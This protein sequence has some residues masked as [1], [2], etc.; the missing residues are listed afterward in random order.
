MIP[1]RA[2]GKGLGGL[3]PAL[4]LATG[5][6]DLGG[7][8]HAAD[9]SECDTY[10]FIRMSYDRY[11]L[12]L[13]NERGWL[14]H[15]EANPLI[16]RSH[17]IK[18][19]KKFVELLDA[20]YRLWQIAPEKDRPALL[21]RVRQIVSVTYQDDYHDMASV[22][23]TTF[24]QD[25]TSYLRAA[26]LMDRM[27]LDTARYRQEILKIQPRLD[28]HLTSRG[29]NQRRIF[30]WYYEHFGLK[31]PFPLADALKAG[32]IAHRQDP[33]R[34]SSLDIYLF[35]HEIFGPY[36]YGD[37]LDV[38]PFSQ[39]DKVYL[40]SALEVLI[41]RSLAARDPDLLA[42]LITCTRLLRLVS[43]PSYREGLAYL[44]DS[45]NA[46]GSWGNIARA[47]ARLGDFAAEGT[48]LH[49]T[50]VA[51]DALSL[52]FHEP[53]YGPLFVSCPKS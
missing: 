6:T 10:R 49:T 31:E 47:R 27:G 37:R 1:G 28:A 41:R 48:L 46:D 39:E 12:A 8:F 2:L 52:A 3:L 45:Q 22:D 13:A 38:D 14:D 24:K 20:Y 32:E 36:E 23:D 53:W 17:G 5:C 44:L 18:G 51:A 43:I 7:H 40:R 50:M 26:L 9:S 42:E 11:R 33:A 30:H 35:T 19:K 34:M 16:L 25:S 29:P 21:D 4:V 15:L